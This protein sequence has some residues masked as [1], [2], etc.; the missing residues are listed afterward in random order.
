M[1]DKLLSQVWIFLTGQHMRH[2]DLW[3]SN[4]PWPARS[5]YNGIRPTPMQWV[6]VSKSGR[7]LAHYCPASNIW[8][9]G[10]GVRP[11]TFDASIDSASTA[12][13]G[14]YLDKDVIY[15]LDYFI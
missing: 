10:S 5:A 12:P 13:S 3:L 2:T 7:E 15:G 6:V 4:R 1:V 11:L 8:C 9:Y 14:T